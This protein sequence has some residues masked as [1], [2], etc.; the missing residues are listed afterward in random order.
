MAS[1]NV[2]QF[3]D[4]NFE[5]EVLSSPVPVLVDFWAEWC[6]PC[7]ML[8]PTIDQLA[9][10][11]KGQVKVGKM[12]TDENREVPVKFNINAIPTVLLFK[13]GQLAHRFV[14]LQPK[15][16]FINAINAAK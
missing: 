1:A 10:E 12:N 6:G 7:R 16:N 11:L 2:V 8:S 14:G 5:A 4:A 9:E 3:T 15:A 13:G